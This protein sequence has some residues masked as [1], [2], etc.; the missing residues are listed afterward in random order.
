MFQF[1]KETNINFSNVDNLF[2]IF[3]TVKKIRNFVF[4]FILEKIE[5]TYYLERIW[6]IHQ[7]H[8]HLL[9]ITVRTYVLTSV[10]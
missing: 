8:K 3:W 1:Q 2:I 4:C 7:S 10:E 5:K 9:M 6:T